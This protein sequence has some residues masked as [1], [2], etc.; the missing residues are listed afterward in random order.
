[1]EQP[2]IL[3]PSTGT[4]GPVE[5]P[6]PPPAFNTTTFDYE[7]S[8][9]GGS[10]IPKIG[11]AGGAAIGGG[12]ILLLVRRRRRKQRERATKRKQVEATAQSAAAKAKGAAGGAANVAKGAA[13]GAA[14]VA[15]GAAG[16][17]GSAAETVGSK[18]RT[19]VDRIAD[20]RNVR[21]YAVAGAAAAWLYLKVA[22]V[23]QLRKLSR[24]VA[25][26]R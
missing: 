9:N 11:I 1:V 4:P 2:D 12:T 8:T 26:A 25:V 24:S 17:V 13:S 23:R 6:L 19:G 3:E 18:F 16:A 21:V 20:D 22:E 5:T 7:P 15:K 14:T 10:Q